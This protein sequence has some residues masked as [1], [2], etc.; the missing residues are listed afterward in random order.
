MPHNLEVAG[1]NPVPATQIEVP[2]KQEASLRLDTVAT[3]RKGSDRGDVIDPD[4]SILLERV[5]TGEADRMPPEG[6][7]LSADQ[8]AAIKAWIAS[9]AVAPR[10]E[11][12]ELDPRQHW[13]YQLPVRAGADLDS[14]LEARLSLKGL[15]AQSAAAPEVWLWGRLDR[16]ISLMRGDAS[17]V[18]G[19]AP[20]L[21]LSM[22]LHQTGQ[23][24]PARET[25]AAAIASCLPLRWLALAPPA[26]KWRVRLPARTG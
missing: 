4:G 23:T 18:L 13:A 21:V 5:S 14:L 26:W 25:L 15:T 9:G 11:K 8:I 24:T 22:A 20:R 3:M 17:R 19:P 2:L 12:P 1:S 6:A 7:R 10:D 16:A